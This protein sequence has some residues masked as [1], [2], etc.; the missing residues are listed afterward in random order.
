MAEAAVAAWMFPAVF[1]LILIGIPVA[2]ALLAVAMAFGYLVFGDIVGIQVQSRLLEV[3]SNYVLSAI[4]LFVFMGAI[5]ERSG[6]AERVFSAL[7]LFL[8]KLPGGIALTTIAMCAIFAAASGVVGAVE[9]LVGLMAMPA[10]MKAGYRNDLIAGSICAGGSLGTI[11]PPSVVVVVYAS[12]TNQSVG[13]L[14]AGVLIP[15]AL[16]VVCF[17]GY[18]FMRALLRPQDAPRADAAELD[19]PLDQK[20]R[21][22][23]SAVLP[24]AGLIT[25]VLGSI[26][27]GVASP[28]EAGALGAG[29]ALLLAAIYRVLTLE[30]F[31][32]AL[33][34]TIS[35]SSMILFIVFG[36]V[37]FTSI[38]MISGGSDLVQ[39]VV[40]GLDLGPTGLVILL[41]AI[42][43]VIGFTMDWVSV[44]LIAVPIFAPII[45]DSGIDPVW[46]GVLV[47]IALQTSYLTPPMAPSIF[48]LRSIA[49]PEMT[50]LEMY[51]GVIPFVG[52]QLLV[53]LIVLLVPEAATWLPDLLFRS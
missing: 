33:R 51:R 7:R 9:V 20:L 30:L 11:I 14:L 25:L 3:A 53:L 34:R 10:M 47:C 48:Y 32:E 40:D 8:G 23:F 50:Y 21:A 24:C 44:I 26:F 22:L 13:D 28:T 15:G 31:I 27:A 45:R 52:M 16:M 39:G 38:F 37:A 18:I 41:L 12:V 43:F 19:V 5:L 2:F 46:F 4:P 29:G 6:V 42:V 1:S 36:G 17:A 35:I 49:P